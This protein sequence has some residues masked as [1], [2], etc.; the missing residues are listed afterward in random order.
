[1]LGGV[2]LIA[3][4][5]V[6]VAI[7]VS[8]N[9]GTKVINADSPAAKQA[10]SSV[11]TLLS[12][13]PE[14]D[15]TLGNPNAKVTVTEYGDLECP[16]CADF[17]TQGP[18]SQIISNYVRTGKAK[19]VYRSLDTASQNSPISNVFPSQ[20][21]AAYAA[22]LQ[23]KAWYYIELFYHE[24]GQEGTGYVTPA[25]LN[26]L[27]KQVPGLN[28]ASWQLDSNNSNLTAQVTADEQAAAARGF[29]ST[30]TVVVT[31]PKGSAQPL[32]G[33]YTFGTY[34]QAINS[35]T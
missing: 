34:Q 7:A 29:N 8:S 15:N 1:M 16:V 26:G 24:Q 11:D 10:A 30:P 12:G 25:Y 6:A 17:A 20:Q 28:Y 32:V 21:A 22:G 5:L 35:V 23:G 3:V 2:L 33:D 27:A 13:I 9:S 31:G 4:A 14:S 18:E 19:L